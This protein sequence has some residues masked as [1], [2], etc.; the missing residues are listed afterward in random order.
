MRKG[1]AKSLEVNTQ[2]V[3][4]SFYS[5]GN[6]LLSIVLKNVTIPHIS[7]ILKQVNDQLLFAF[8]RFGNCTAYSHLDFDFRYKSS[9]TTFYNF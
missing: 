2:T 5:T 7:S 9:K 6:F 4:T 3:V 1:D 8:L